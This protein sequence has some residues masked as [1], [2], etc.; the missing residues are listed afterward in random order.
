MLEHGD[1]A[2]GQGCRG[3]VQT[4]AHRYLAEVE[5]RAVGYID[6][7]NDDDIT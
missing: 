4:A 6:S 5:G 1:R 7:D 3:A 2:I